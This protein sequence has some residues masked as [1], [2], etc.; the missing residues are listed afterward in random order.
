MFKPKQE[1]RVRKSD[2]CL[3]NSYNPAAFP[4]AYA[5]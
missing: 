5:Y 2:L 1:Y 4:Y 3:I